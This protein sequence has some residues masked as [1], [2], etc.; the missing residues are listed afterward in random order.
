MKLQKSAFLIIMS[1]C[2]LFG[3]MGINQPV[4]AGVTVD[5]G[6]Y[7]LLLNKYVKDGLVDY[8]GFKKETEV[9][10]INSSIVQPGHLSMIRQEIILTVLPC[11]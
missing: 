4:W 5:N 10:W 7:A 1:L 2:L 3:S 11:L 9:R 6:I 8:R